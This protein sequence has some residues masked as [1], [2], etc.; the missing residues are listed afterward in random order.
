MNRNKKR[1]IKLPALL[2]L[3]VAFLL[4]A[5]GVLLS[6]DTDM[7]PIY[8]YGAALYDVENE[9]YLYSKHLR[10]QV[11]PASITKLLSMY[12]CFEKVS[13]L[14]ED[15]RVESADLTKAINNGASIAKLKSGHTY[16]YRDLFKLALYQSAADATYALV[17]QLYGT[18]ALC[19]NRMNELASTIGMSHSHFSNTVGLT[20]S[21]LYTTNE[22]LVKLMLYVYQDDDFRMLF[23][24]ADYTTVDGEYQAVNPAS[25]YADCAALKTGYTDKSQYTQ[26][27]TFVFH[28]HTI[29]VTTTG[30]ATARRRRRDV[31]NLSGYA[32]ASYRPI[33]K[34]AKALRRL[35]K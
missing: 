5:S 28:K 9:T 31:Q 7:P 3:I 2:A 18:E 25:R 34:A 21:G 32:K 35:F 23:Q 10:K 22:D 1:R 17:R 11:H 20:D 19:V 24:G 14:D 30:A 27:S 13:N 8:S 16:T 4:I 26:A 12:A 29:I 6:Y 15:V 33:V